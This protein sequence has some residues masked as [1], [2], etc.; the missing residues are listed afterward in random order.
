MMRISEASRRDIFDIIKYGFTGTITETRS[1][2][3]EREYSVEV[4]CEFKMKYYGRIMEIDFLKRLYDLEHMPSNDYAYRSALGEIWRHTVLSE[5]WE[6]GWVFEDERF[7][8]TK[9][10]D[11]KYLLDF[12][13]EMFNPFVRDEQSDWRAILEALQRILQNSGYELVEKTHPIGAI[14]YE[15]RDSRKR[16]AVANR[17]MNQIKSAFNSDY[18]CVQIDSILGQIDSAPHF[19]IGK[20][21]ELLET[22]CKSILD[23]Q[24]V[25]YA[26]DIELTS[27]MKVT[28]ENIGLSAKKLKEDIKGKEVAAKILGNL[29]AI[30]HGMAELRNLYGDGHG[31]SKSFVPLPPRYA[32]LA[33]GAS[34][35][36]VKFLWDT[37]TERYKNS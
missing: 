25:E 5:D 11:D 37:Y 13:Q 20:A 12:I 1:D 36:C 8:L 26:R 19:A 34:A 29:S 28:C 27:L 14:I 22:C 35:A 23:E 21:K 6:Y 31:K 7:C 15:W 30:A 3:Y 10:N 4:P 9:G 17:Q 2:E 32:E 33:V 16:N 18:I 24:K